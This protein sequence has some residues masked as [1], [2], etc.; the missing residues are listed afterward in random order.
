MNFVDFHSRI[1]AEVI[2]L[3]ELYATEACEI[4]KNNE[5]NMNNVSS[6]IKRNLNSRY[7]ILETMLEY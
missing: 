4:V 3:Q 1:K 7:K 6:S 5:V 2:N